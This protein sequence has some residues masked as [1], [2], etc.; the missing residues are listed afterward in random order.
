MSR[1][2]ASW[3]RRAHAGLNPDWHYT[4]KSALGDYCVAVRG[5]GKVVYDV[6]QVMV[7]G[8]QVWR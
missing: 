7:D 8:E 4:V 1:S 3:E 6:Q 5:P 2:C